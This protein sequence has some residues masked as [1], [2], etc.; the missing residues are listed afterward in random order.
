MA[1]LALL[2]VAVMTFG[3]ILTSRLNA[4]SRF[5]SVDR[6]HNAKVLAQAKRALIGWMAANA[7]S[8]DANPG[9]LPC[10]EAPAY[11]ADP[12]QQGVAAG[13]CTLPAVGRLPWR[14]LGLDRLV[15][16]AGEPLWYVVSPGW[17]LPTLIP[18]NSD[19]LGQL[20]LD[21]SE[22]V[23]LIIAPG[24][25]L[26]VQAGTGCT[27]WV[28][29][30]PIAG[31]P[32]LR[33]YLE[34]ENATSPADASFVTRSAGGSFN[35]QVLRVSAADL[36]PALEAAIADRVQ[37]EIAPALATGSFVLDSSS[38]RRWVTA[39]GNPPIYPYAAP[40]ADPGTSLYMG[41]DGIYQ[42]LLPFHPSQGFVAYQATPA[43]AVETLG[44][45]YLMSQSCYWEAAEAYLCAGRYHE[46]DI[47]PT[48]P[49][50]IQM[51]ATF[52]NVAMG[53]RSLQ[54]ANLQVQA[55]D[56]G[57]SGP[58][59][60]LT[61][62]YRA[63]MNDGSVSGK[64]RGSVTIRFWATLPNIDAMGWGTQ[65][66]Y[67]IRIDRAMI[68]DHCLL[69]TTTSCPGPSTTWF[70]RNEW[71]RNLY[72]AVAQDNTAY[73]LPSVGG[74]DST[75]CLRFNDPATRNIRLLLVLAG[76]RLDTQTRPSSTLTDYL[77]LQ[78]ADLGTLYEQRQ[79]RAS[80]IEDLTL[81]APWNDR[82][83]LVDWIS[84]NPTFPLANLP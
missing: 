29:S 17:A 51:T 28:Q 48:L 76:R 47:D 81:N 5:A 40:F 74:C 8:T 82:L 50:R 83:V 12:A 37:R 57:S 59:T 41:Q 14:T 31:T 66:D 84:P 45:G 13:G 80:K 27:A 7:V 6:A 77:E 2:A 55:R 79:R 33:N 75:S 67:R 64:P 22:A 24:V 56:D 9:R 35:D 69:S 10:P 38:P 53:L 78:N 26:S 39:S 43:D 72:Y 62:S 11:F 32:E 25:A 61:P 16:D 46:D 19:S 71:Q 65:A 54:P 63:E 60:D 49:M 70:A 23:A 30:R 15:D 4:A 34:C 52:T 20:S 42:G 3:Y 58:W 44:N 36:M 21:G 68:D 18:I 1:L 73:V